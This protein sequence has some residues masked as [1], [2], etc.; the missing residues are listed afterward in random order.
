L[1]LQKSAL[2]CI[3][4]IEPK[5]KSYYITYS[6]RFWIDADAAKLIHPHLLSQHRSLGQTVPGSW[7]S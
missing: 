1:D 3:L 4:S 5:M 2:L 7:D 6:R